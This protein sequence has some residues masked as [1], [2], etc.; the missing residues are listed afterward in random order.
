MC[1]KIGFLR[2][3][4]EPLL[5][6]IEVENL[7]TLDFCKRSEIRLLKI[8]IENL[9]KLDFLRAKRATF[10]ENREYKIQKS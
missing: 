4:S 8:E 5:L 10:A 3:P 1:F 6:K 7:Q 2:E 9:S